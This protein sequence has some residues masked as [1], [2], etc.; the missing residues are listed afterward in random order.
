MESMVGAVQ[1]PGVSSSSGA[2]GLPARVVAA[3]RAGLGLALS[4]E[5]VVVSDRLWAYEIEAA[6]IKLASSEAVAGLVRVRAYGDKVSFEP[7]EPS[8]LARAGPP[9]RRSADPQ[10]TRAPG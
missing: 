10:G 4:G 2:S 5:R 9:S 6:A 8:V 7:V 3:A 1:Q